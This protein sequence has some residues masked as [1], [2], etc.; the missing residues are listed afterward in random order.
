MEQVLLKMRHLASFLEPQ[1]EHVQ[2]VE[3]LRLCVPM[4]AYVSALQ[5]TVLIALS[6]LTN[7]FTDFP[8]QSLIGQYKEKS[9][10][11]FP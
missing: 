9:E 6:P 8:V 1:G 7:P 2:L 4:R 5:R 10:F 3:T 11:K